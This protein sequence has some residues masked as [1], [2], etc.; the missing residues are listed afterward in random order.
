MAADR[1]ITII[2]H[3]IVGRLYLVKLVERGHGGNKWVPYIGTDPT[4]FFAE[5]LARVIARRAE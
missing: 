3:C 5:R 4:G 1:E 2:P